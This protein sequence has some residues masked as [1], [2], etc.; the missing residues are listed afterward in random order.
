M[1]HLALVSA[2]VAE[3]DV[4]WR[5][6]LLQILYIQGSGLMMWEGGMRVV[7]REKLG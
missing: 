5:G 2:D 3:H 4:L 7:V 1:S 6:V